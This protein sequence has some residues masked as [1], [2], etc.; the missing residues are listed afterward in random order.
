MFKCL[1]VCHGEL[2]N[3]H[4]L[5]VAANQC[6][7]NLL[8]CQRF[9]SSSGVRER[10]YTPRW[11]HPALQ[12]LLRKSFGRLCINIVLRL[13]G[14]RVKSM[15]RKK[16]R[17]LVGLTSITFAKSESDQNTI[18]Y[19]DGHALKFAMNSAAYSHILAHICANMRLYPHHFTFLVSAWHSPNV[20]ISILKVKIAVLKMFL[21]IFN[22]KK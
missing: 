3:R 17:C 2:S 13:P 16:T 9:T 1:N 4:I 18:H 6:R 14:Q 12:T 15:Q 8:N 19:R 5:L 10:T 21:N 22:N 7:P 11:F 20:K